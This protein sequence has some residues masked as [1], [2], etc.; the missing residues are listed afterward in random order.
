MRLDIVHEFPFPV[1][2]LERLMMH[3]GL[4]DLLVAQVPL[5]VAV[6][7]RAFSR[8][9]NRIERRLSYKPKPVIQYVGT[10]KVE[11]EW[12]EWIEESAFDLS[13]HRG[14]FKNV[15]VKRR[16]AEVFDNHGT[17]RVEP[18]P[19]GCKRTILTELNIKLFVVGKLAERMIAPHAKEL[20]D[21]E[22]ALLVK[23]YREKL[24]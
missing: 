19:N 8:D 4:P 22:A 10:K 16:I 14:S 15:P 7:I 12:M 17:L 13:T 9:G 6:Q 3:P 20:L 23:A 18:T 24:L 5:L 21:A 2:E 1:E 11:P